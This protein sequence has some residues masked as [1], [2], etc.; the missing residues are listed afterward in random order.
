M[1]RDIRLRYAD[2]TDPP[3]EEGT[4]AESEA[5]TTTEE[6]TSATE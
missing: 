1:I 4:P 3:A 2:P 5:E 6:S